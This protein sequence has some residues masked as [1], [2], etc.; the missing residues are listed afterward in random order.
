ML[1]LLSR[2]AAVRGL[3][4]WEMTAELGVSQRGL[5]DHSEEA[6]AQISDLMGLGEARWSELLSWTPVPAEGVRM[7]F[8]GEEVV[9]RSVANPTVRGCSKCLSE[10][11]ELAINHPADAMVMRG[12][13]QLRDV[14]LCVRHGQP[15]VELWRPG[16]WASANT[17]PCHRERGGTQF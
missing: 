7:Q 12:D 1:S 2:T 17:P 4:T 15:L 16:T 6:V 13:W 9:S 14:H 5:I 11:M 8:R 10:D 3:T